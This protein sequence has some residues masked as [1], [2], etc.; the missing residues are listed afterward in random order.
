MAVEFEQLNL[1]TEISPEMEIREGFDLTL[2]QLVDS[3]FPDGSPVQKVEMNK[4]LHLCN[5]LLSSADVTYYLSA[6][7]ILPF[8]RKQ[9]VS[10]DENANIINLFTE[11]PQ[12]LAF[13]LQ[14]KLLQGSPLTFYIGYKNGHNHLDNLTH[15]IEAIQESL[16]KRFAASQLEPEKYG[17]NPAAV[18]I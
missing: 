7:N 10:K 17:L 1:K 6:A 13:N 5:E 8:I 4:L 2:T 18:F 15:T 11:D 14:M 16:E 9:S 12:S 3:F